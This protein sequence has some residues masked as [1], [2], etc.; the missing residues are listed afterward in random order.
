MKT[1]P[2]PKGKL[3]YKQKTFADKIINNPKDSATEAAATTYK[4]TNRHSA[5][6]IAYENL[7]KPEIV[8]YLNRHLKDAET[9][10]LNVMYN[11]EKMKDEPQHANIAIRSAEMVMDRVIGKPTQRVEQQS[12]S[13]NINLDLTGVEQ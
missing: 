2:K 11:S 4:V 3:T 1:P 10:V 8:S 7:R 9:T 5:E 6:Q 12:T 13:V